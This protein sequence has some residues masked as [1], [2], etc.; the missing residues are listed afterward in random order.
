MKQGLWQFMLVWLACWAGVDGVLAADVPSAPILRLEA[1]MHTA[2]IRRIDTDASGRYAVTASEDK[3]ARVWEVASGR[4]LQTLRV[5]IGPGDEGKLYAVAITPDAKVVAVAGWTKLGSDSGHTIYLFARESGQLLRRLPGLP[6]VIRHLAFS[7]D[8]RWLAATLG[9]GNGVRVWDWQ[10]N[11]PPLADAAYG[12]DSYGASWSQD[13]RLATSSYDGKLRLYRLPTAPNK[14]RA[15]LQKL[16]EQAAPGGKQSFAVAFAPDG[17][18]LAVGYADSTRVDVVDGQT[19]QQRFAANTQGV[20]NGNLGRV[21]WSRDGQT[22]VA[23]GRWA[24]NGRHMVR[25]WPQAGRGPAQDTATS[26][27][28]ITHLASLPGGGWLVGASDPAWGVLTNTGIWQARAGAPQADLRGSL[29]DAFL[30]NQNGSKLQFGYEPW[31]K[32]AHQFDVARRQLSAGPLADGVAARTSGL[33]VSD[34]ENNT[35]PKLNGQALPLHE[36]ETARSLAISPDAASLV[37]GADFGLRHFSKAGQPLWP[38]PLAVPGV[39]WSVN[40]PAS[41]KLVVAAYADGTIRWHRLADGQ[42]LLAFFPH[43]DRKRWVLWTPSGYYDASPGGEALIGWHVNNGMDKAA[44]FFPAAQFRSKFYRPDVIDQILDTLDETKAVAQADQAAQRRQ[45]AA[46][47]AKALPPVVEL[48]SPT[49]VRTSS[50]SIAVRVRARSASDAPVQAWRVR[51]N[52][53]AL[54]DVRGLARPDSQATADSE[55]EFTITIPQQNSRIELFAENRHGT[56]LPATLQVQWVASTPTANPN[57]NTAA[58]NAFQIRPKLYVLAIGVASYQHTSIP[59]LG[60]PAKDASDFAKVLR[61]Q[62]GGLYS[63]VEVKLLANQ[64]ATRDEI[65]DGLDWL[66]KSVTQHDVGMLFFAGHAINDGNLGYTFLPFN[67]DPDKLK[68][69]GV[70]MTDIRSTLSALTGKALF[71]FD[72]CHAGNVLGK[73]TRAS[74]NDVMGVVNELSSAENGVVVFSSSTGRQLSYEDAAWGNGAFTKALVEGLQ[75]KADSQ[76]TGRITHKMLDLYISERVKEL[77]KGKQSPVTQAPGGVQ[78][79]PLVILGGGK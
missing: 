58:A 23:A 70:S 33:A 34:W 46:E 29:R 41:G 10:Q 13:G 62:Q 17:R 67:A 77:T 76:K 32:P 35:Q 43:A 61:A 3:T 39:V 53:Q 9:V 73:A 57:A 44:D 52:G 18:S 19:L 71:F 54:P 47:I 37:L 20:A 59:K 25:R 48:L 63:N 69:T 22:L 49:E 21:A 27:S 16:A 4:L 31:G 60:L 7:P 68:K 74:A 28:T 24:S 72:T 12:S 40:I 78:D 15:S 42:E 14:G 36:Y 5:P 51:V 65:I 64:Q 6:N 30:L 2:A 45:Q 11:R 50:T 55:R 56:S 38:A 8:G 79:F 26:Q 75:G 66:Q 1:G